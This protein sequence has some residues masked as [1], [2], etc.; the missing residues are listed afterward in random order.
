MT[1]AHHVNRYVVEMSVK[2]NNT[3]S[4]IL[5][6]VLLMYKI[7]VKDESYEQIR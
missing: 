5:N 4:Y 7:G 1:K 6:I 2:R 3:L